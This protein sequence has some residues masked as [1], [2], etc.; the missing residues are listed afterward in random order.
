MDKLFVPGDILLPK[1]ADM[2][3]WSVIACDQYTSQPEYWDAVD[4]RVGDAP[5]TLRLILPEAYLEVKD[6]SAETERINRTMEKYLEEDLFETVENSYIY[7]ERELSE[8]KTRRGLVGLI[9]LEAYD[10]RSDSISPV[11]ATEGTVE[12]RLPPRVKIR[13]GAWLE[14]PHIVVFT[15][16]LDNAVFNGLDEGEKLYDFGLMDGGGHITGRRVC[17]DAADGVQSALRGLADPNYLKKRYAL[18]N[19][20]PVIIAMGDGNHSLATARLCWEQLRDGLSPEERANHPARF[21]LAELVN[22]HDP[23]IEFEP[24]HRVLFEID[25]KC[26]F[27]EAESFFGGLKGEGNKNHKIRLACGGKTADVFVR[28]LTIGNLI[29]ASQR[30]CVKYIE[31]HGGKLDYIHGDDTALEMAGRPGCAGLLLPAM[32]KNELFPSIM[33]SGVFPAKSFSI[34]PARDKRYYLECRKIK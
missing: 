17:G 16:D 24:I 30:F 10:Y 2:A 12:S 33:E 22:I 7:V 29:A 21:G 31:K 13:Q 27:E 4:S 14:L 19:G 6:V 15:D 11:H 25:A 3:L 23:S 20:A 26:Y 32:D 28:G 8:G 1:N 9:D 34:G 18:K 5:S